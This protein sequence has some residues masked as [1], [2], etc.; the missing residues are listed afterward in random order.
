MSV[1][2]VSLELTCDNAAAELI[3]VDDE[4][5]VIATGASPLAAKVEPG[6]YAL[7]AKI[8]AQV[9]E[10]LQV[11]DGS[12]PAYSFRVQSPQFESPMPLA[13][14]S[15]SREY[16]QH[17]LERF[18]GSGEHAVALGEGSAIVLF[19]RDTS[20]RNVAL[21]PEEATEYA[22]S[23]GGF[24]LLDAAGRELV[25][26]D[27]K[28]ARNIE[29][30][31]IGARVRLA[32]GHYVL[33]WRH[34]ARGR[35]PAAGSNM[36]ETRLALHAAPG[37]SLNVFIRLQAATDASAMVPNFADAAF[38]YDRIDT[39][40]SENR[41]DLLV[42]EAARAAL[43]DRRNV[44]TGDEMRSLLAGKH[45]NPMLG[46]YGG[47][48]LAAAADVDSKLLGQVI[49]STAALL[50]NDHPDIAALAWLHESRKGERPSGFGARPWPEIL[51]ALKGP[52]LLVQ[53]WDALLACAQAARLDIAGLPAFAVAGDLAVSGIVLT[54]EHREQRG[55]PQARP[56]TGLGSPLA[57]LGKAIWNTIAHNVLGRSSAPLPS[58]DVK[59]EDITTPEAAAAAM[60]LLA[61]KAHWDKWLSLV[62]LDR[63][64]ADRVATFSPLQRD[65]IATLART[66]VDPETVEGV[67]GNYIGSIMQAHRVPL[68]TV[69]AA[70]RALDVVAVSVEII[71]RIKG[72]L[73]DPP[74]RK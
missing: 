19:V 3:V 52:P 50:G 36:Q 60:R 35:L 58:L 53:S 57:R 37:W 40:Y 65:L 31:Y 22:R 26:F 30:G 1:S 74:A 73:V 41:S 13:N 21:K 23:F 15:T 54:W 62:H 56:A 66:T 14:T 32:P 20:R 33:A 4:F 29:D 71:R 46:L 47:H 44:A 7:K 42:L 63:A 12:Q 43:L 27:D 70:L 45:D 16:Q 39:P 25:N 68:S 8:G 67:D 69:A 5:R 11:I 17:S 24:R 72:A 64:R 55:E 61:K 28:A 2:E 49:A 38:A 51:G 18:T 10:S 6:I 48:M 34:G 9:S 59:V